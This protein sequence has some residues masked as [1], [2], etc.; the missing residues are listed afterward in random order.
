MDPRRPSQRVMEHPAE[1]E[2]VGAREQRR[3]ERVIDA[4]V[5]DQRIEVDQVARGV[6][7]LLVVKEVRRAVHD[8]VG[9][10][11][12]GEPRRIGQG[13]RGVQQQCGV[14][15]RARS[16]RDDRVVHVEDGQSLDVLHRRQLVHPLP[17]VALVVGVMM[18]S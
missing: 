15:M 4:E 5:A 18:R 13:N 10:R 17:V 9:G 11:E 16:L 6:A 1:L 3:P 14:G 7:E 2:L 12:H 8:H